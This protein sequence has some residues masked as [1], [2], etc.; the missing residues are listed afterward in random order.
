MLPLAPGAG[1]AHSAGEDGLPG[2]TET[3][4][5]LLEAGLVHAIAIASGDKP[6]VTAAIVRQLKGGQNKKVVTSVT[7]FLARFAK[8]TQIPKKIVDRADLVYDVAATL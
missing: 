8:G 1:A 2:L 5:R 7:S 4:K 6:T 3:Q